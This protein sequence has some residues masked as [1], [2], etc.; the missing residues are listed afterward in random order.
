MPTSSRGG[1]TL[2]PNPISGHITG[3]GAVNG[4]LP[5]SPV[6]AHLDPTAAPAPT[7][8]RHTLPA[9]GLE[10]LNAET[11]AASAPAVA[12]FNRR[13]GTT[14]HDIPAGWKPEDIRTIHEQAAKNPDVASFW[15]GLVNPIDWGVQGVKGARQAAH[16]VGELAHGKLARGALDVGLGGLSAAAVLPVGRGA[17]ALRE[18]LAAEKAVTRALKAGRFNAVRDIAE[19]TAPTGEQATRAALAA[20]KAMPHEVFRQIGV[21]PEEFARHLVAGARMRYWYEES[22]HGILQMAGGNRNLADKYAQ[23]TAIMSAQKEPLPNIQ[24]ANRAIHEFQTT[25][26]VLSGDVHQAAKATAVLRGEKWN[27]VK[28]DR[29]YK[30]MLEE[31]NPRKYKRLFGNGE[32]TNDIWM[33]RLYGLKSDVP[34]PREYEAMTKA[35]QAAAEELGWKPKQVQ[36]AQWISKKA[37]SEPRAAAGGASTFADALAL[38][39]ARVPFEAAPGAEAAPELHAKYQALGQQQREAYTAAKAD[40]VRQYLRDAEVMGRM[41]GSGPASSRARSALDAPS[42]SR[43]P[44]RVA[45]TARLT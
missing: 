16:G 29:F 18:G 34:T 32:V 10:Q 31:I 33:A 22:A 2:P 12:D 45:R 42:I 43:R 14:Y 20:F 8:P 27:G 1:V 21:T 19:Q 13:A 41:G 35:T 11:Q 17:R 25:G 6:A 36:A 37:E 3:A 15:G 30:N 5:D 23:V 38:E 26:R 39:H 7:A 9:G 24:L 44:A 40:L 28:T 4:R